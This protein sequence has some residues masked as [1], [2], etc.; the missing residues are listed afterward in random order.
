MTDRELLIDLEF[1][2]IAKL[3]PTFLIITNPEED[4]DGDIQIVMACSQF[5]NK[6]IQERISIIFKLISDYMPDIINIR[7][8]VVQAYSNS[9]M[10]KVLDD[11]FSR[12]LF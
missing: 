1:L 3:R 7:L 8:I 10:D 2:L 11:L 4:E 5:A 6:S 9:E 12:E